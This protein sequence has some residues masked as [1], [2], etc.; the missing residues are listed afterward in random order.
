MPIIWQKR[1]QPGSLH[2]LAAF[3]TSMLKISEKLKLS[4]LWAAIKA[5]LQ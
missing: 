2:V 4:E 3:E 1:P 5:N